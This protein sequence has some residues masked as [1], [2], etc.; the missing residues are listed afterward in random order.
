MDA[1][2]K[3]VKCVSGFRCPSQFNLYPPLTCEVGKYGIDGQCNYCS[4]GKFCGRNPKEYNEYSY[5]TKQH[6]C[7][8]GFICSFEGLGYI[9]KEIECP[10]GLICPE[11]I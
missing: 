3:I 4:K 8:A 1:D 7:P 6:D 10:G 2:K 5:Y 11:G 9:T